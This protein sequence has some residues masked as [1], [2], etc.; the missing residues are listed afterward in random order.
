M[1]DKLYSLSI[2]ISLFESGWMFQSIT[3]LFGFEE[4]LIRTCLVTSFITSSHEFWRLALC[5]TVLPPPKWT[6]SIHNLSFSL[7]SYLVFKV[8]FFLISSKMT[9]PP[10]CP[11]YVFAILPENAISVKCINAFIKKK[12]Y[13]TTICREFL[14]SNKSIQIPEY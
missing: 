14:L 3:E 12:L 5:R 8:T 7:V 10:S 9:T 13:L 11:H 4:I 2:Y 6:E 1:V